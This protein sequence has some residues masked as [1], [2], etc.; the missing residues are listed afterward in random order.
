MQTLTYRETHPATDLGLLAILGGV[1]LRRHEFPRWPSFSRDEIKAV[2]EVL[3]S[4]K[5]NYW[6]GEQCRLFEREFADFHERSY[7]VALANGT[8]A[9]EA[10][11]H[12]LGIG[13]GDDVTVPSKTFIA[14]ASSVVMRGARPI[15]A[16][17][18]LV[19]QNITAATICRAMT[20]RTRAVI[21][22][23]LAGWPCDMD[24]ILAFARERGIVVI[25][26]CAQAH[27]ARYKGRVVGSMGDAAAFSFCQDKI[28]TTGGEGGM[29]LLNDEAAWKRAWSLKDH[30]KDYDEANHSTTEH[31]F[32]WVHRSFGTNWRMT[33]MQAALG[34]LQLRTLR[35]QVSV[36]TRNATMLRAYFQNVPGLRVTIPPAGI[37][38]A[39]YKYYCFLVP[40][41]LTAGWTRDRVIAAIN[42]E[43]IPCFG[44]SCSEIYREQAFP[45]E[46]RPPNQLPVAMQLENTSLM[47][48]VHPTLTS[49][50][51]LDT[52]L[53]VHKVLSH[54]GAAAYVNKAR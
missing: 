49:E 54:V 4:G 42:A 29:L 52:C 2:A 16:D 20:P 30:G 53:G 13:P 21:V 32:R 7:A 12:A 51:M 1:P 24:P 37:D 38:H 14:T 46:L 45:P 15:V 18:D 9:L 47:F 25:E 3:R 10:A 23:H 11:L 48:L 34:R 26:D 36:R 44:G 19:S 33:E 22:V 5:V 17:V 28:I 31:G 40:E 43:G 50:D 41:Q 35:D 27:G 8:V 39:Y 6:T